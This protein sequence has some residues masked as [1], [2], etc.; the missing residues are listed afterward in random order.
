MISKRYVHYGM[1]VLSVLIAG[2][3]FALSAQSK[4]PIPEKAVFPGLDKLLH[5]TAFGAL[6]F[7]F[8]Y[9]FSDE[10]WAAK[11]VKYIA[12]VCAAAAFYGITDEFHQYFVPGRDTSVY[13]WFADCAGAAIAAFCR[14]AIVRRALR[15]S[16]KS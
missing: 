12:L 15:S 8:S 16:A 3:I 6:A 10:K 2:A 9:W 5:A 13:D 1:R 11:P 7:A 4:L 14:Y